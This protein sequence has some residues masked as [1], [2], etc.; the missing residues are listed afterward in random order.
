[1][2]DH[3]H[4]VPIL[5]GKDG[6]YG[7]LKELNS[8]TKSGLTP[9]IEVISIPWDFQNDQPK[10]TID[11]HLDDVAAKIL[12]SWGNTQPLY[13]D[14]YWIDE[15]ERMKDGR[16]YLTFVFD[17]TRAKGVLGIP[18]TG[19]RRDADYQLAVKTIVA[20][21]KRGVCIRLE[22]ED[23]TEL[24]DLN[25]NLDTL[26][27]ALGVAKGDVDLLMDFREVGVNQTAS[28]ALA[29]QSI[30]SLLANV[31]DWRG[32]IFA[33]TGFPSEMPG[34]STLTLA[35]R[36]E[37]MVWQQLAKH[38]KRLSRLP[39][40]G[41]YAISSPDLLDDVDPRMM[42]LSAAIRYTTDSDWLLIKAGLLRKKGFGQF[43]DLSKLLLG[44]PEYKG[45]SHCWG[46]E[47][48]SLCAVRTQQPGS[49]MT[50][51]KVGTNH[52]LTLVQQQVA[53]YALP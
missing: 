29:A 34:P 24:F 46:D 49:L 31:S 33:G 32:L 25:S 11:T 51:R 43:H 2:F 3:T 30:I 17:D 50:W 22:N 14:P 20:A 36:T 12:A 27:T 10:E 7:A 48:V 19:L 6:E 41:D 52:H 16:H 4:Y 53:S 23:F 26:L 18:V 8:A 44:R 5:K 39:T 37:W 9:L 40:F 47:Y 13:V 35:P 38:H 1:M 15:S 42:K 21:D 45:S 28:V